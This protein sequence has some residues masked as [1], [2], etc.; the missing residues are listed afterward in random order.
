MPQYSLDFGRGKGPTRQNAFN[1]R[2]DH[3]SRFHSIAAIKEDSKNVYR[4][5]PPKEQSAKKAQKEKAPKPQEEQN[6]FKRSHVNQPTYSKVVQQAV[7]THEHKVPK[8]T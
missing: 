3:I 2:C 4:Y 7:E 1:K 5:A 6:S 8:S